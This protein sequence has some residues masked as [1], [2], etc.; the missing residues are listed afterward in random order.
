[1]NELNLY[2]GLG[3][4]GLVRAEVVFVVAA[5]L[6]LIFGVVK[7]I[8]FAHGSFYMV[9]AFIAYSVVRIMPASDGAFWVTLVVAAAVIAAVGI[10]T[11][12]LLLRPIYARPHLFQ[13][14][15]TYGLTLVIAD[16]VRIIWGTAFKTISPPLLLSGSLTLMG[17]SYSTFYL[18]VIGLGITVLIGMWLMLEKTRF[19]LFVRAASLDS[20]MLGTLGINVPLLLTAVFAVGSALAGFAGAVIAPSVS[21][22]PGMEASMLTEAFLVIVIGGMGSIWGAFLASI[23]IGEVFAFGTLPLPQFAI[24]FPYIIGAIVLIVRPQGLFGRAYH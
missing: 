23:I 5:G 12:V 6:T 19:G 18:F 4:S 16:L 24:L 10:L 22:D 1:M 21:I 13:I 3:F 7:I 17:R 8:N 11:E 15:L 14:L 9:G 20:E 2:L